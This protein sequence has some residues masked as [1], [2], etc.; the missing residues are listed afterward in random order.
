M[1]LKCAPPMLRVASMASVRVVEKAV[2]PYYLTEEH[3]QWRATV[4]A[5]AGNHCQG[6]DCDREGVRLYADHIVEVKDG[7]SPCDPENGQALCGSC[8]GLKTHA[9]RRRRLGS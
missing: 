2:A 8:H 9:E 5:R 3:R 1:A 6:K 4:I 7:G